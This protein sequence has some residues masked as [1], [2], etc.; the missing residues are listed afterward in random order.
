MEH[1]IGIFHCIMIDLICSFTVPPKF[2]SLFSAKNP[3]TKKS[4]KF[5]SSDDDSDS[6]FT[7]K[8]VKSSKPPKAPKEAKAPK[9]PK[10]HKEA[11][12]PKAPKE[13]KEPKAPKESK[14]PKEPKAA[15]AP[16]AKA[17]KPKWDS[18][19][20]DEDEFVAKKVGARSKC[21]LYIV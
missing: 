14:P 12:A 21:T 7:S 5:L 8:P 10:E 13:P 16:K 11:K 9:A 6:E 4:S 15:Q 17:K 20:E 19:S 3:P 2:F 1:S 18:G